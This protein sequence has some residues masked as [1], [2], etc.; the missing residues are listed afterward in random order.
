M[1]M[2]PLVP[3]ISGAAAVTYNYFLFSACHRNTDALLQ[4]WNSVITTG[5]RKISSHRLYRG[6]QKY[7]TVVGSKTY[8]SQ[9]H[10]IS[11]VP[12]ASCCRRNNMLHTLI[13]LAILRAQHLSFKV[14]LGILNTGGY[15][16]YCK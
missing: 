5:G 7:G 6:C 14:S 4:R 16:G 10:F 8:L 1:A 12:T 2:L 15:C 3:L 13:K 11:A 9:Q